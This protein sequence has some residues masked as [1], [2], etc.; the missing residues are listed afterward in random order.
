[1]DESADGDH[2]KSAVHDFIGL[3]LLEGSWVFPEPKRIKT[4][5]AG[6]AL[7]F[8]SLLERIA[9]DTLENDN[10][11]KDLAHTASRDEIIMGLNRKYMRKVRVRESPE[12]LNNHTESGKHTNATMLDFGGLKEAD[13]DVI[14]NEKGVELVRSWKSIKILRLKKERNALAHLH[15]RPRGRRS[16]HWGDA[17]GQ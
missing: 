13:I 4:K 3:V 12:F 8:N 2:G 11:E 17:G 5:V 9:A 1:M 16:A 7:S 14:R 6:L 10:E 15:C